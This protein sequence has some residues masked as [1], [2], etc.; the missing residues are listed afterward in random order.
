MQSPKIPCLS[1]YFW[2]LNVSRY[3]CGGGCLL[4]DPVED[5]SEVNAT[6]QEL[7]MMTPSTSLMLLSKGRQS[8]RTTSEKQHDFE[9]PVP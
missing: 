1:R 8:S 2:A 7:Q 9:I 4:P 3:M 5:S 6:K